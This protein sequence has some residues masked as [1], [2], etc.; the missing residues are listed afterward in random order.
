MKIKVSEVT[1]VQLNWL[2]ALCE[3]E[4]FIAESGVNGIGMEFEATDYTANWAQGGAIIDRERIGVWP[5]DCIEGMWAAQSD[6]KVYPERL[7]PYY[8][9]TPL[10]AAMRCYVASKLGDEIELPKELT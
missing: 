1:P 8:G 4:Y 7:S 6:Y 3:G 10:I 5:S 9:V 2:V